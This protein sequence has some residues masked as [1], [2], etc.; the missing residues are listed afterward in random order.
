M[1]P[2]YMP[3]NTSAGDSAPVVLDQYISPTDTLLVVELF[4][5]T[6]SSPS[7]TVKYSPDDP[8]ATY[9]TSYAANANWYSVTGLTT[10][11]T[12]T[13]ATLVFPA[14]AVKLTTVNPGT[15]GTQTPQLAVIQAG[16]R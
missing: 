11:A 5:N 9:A 6:S 8:Y 4:G 13:S 12:D 2:V 7:Y 3:A 1:R 16:V 14:R 15:G 10:L